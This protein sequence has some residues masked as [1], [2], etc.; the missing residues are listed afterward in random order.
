MVE[1][2]A[3]YGDG[4]IFNL[5]PSSALPKMMEHV[6][7]GAERA[8]KNW[9]D[10]EIVNRAMVLATDDKAHGRN[11]FRAAFA[12]YFATPV[13]NKFLAWAGFEDTAETINAGWAAKDREKTT[14]A[15]SDELIDEIA[16]IGTEE[17]IRERIQQDADGGVHTHIVA[18]LAASAEEV[19]RTFATFT[20]DK[21]QFSG[22]A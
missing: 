15:F 2:A 1:M 21:F 18:P 19:E 6:R 5:W 4:V 9:E 10:V 14:G 22:S 7:I 20:A 13:Y 17:E 3:E 11:L 8:G 12:P 16:I